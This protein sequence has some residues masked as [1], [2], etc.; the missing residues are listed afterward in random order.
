MAAWRR[1]ALESF[2]QFRRELN[3][4]GFSIYML[5]FELVPLV[6]QAH[7]DADER[8]LHEIYGFANWCFE[9]HNGELRNATGV[10]YYEHLFDD[11]SLRHDVAKWIT[12]E[13]ERSCWCL[14]ELRLESEKLLALRG[15]FTERDRIRARKRPQ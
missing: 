8:T 15:V 4:P 2:P 11:W 14:W 7:K 12:P 13:I 6:R 5:Y 3:D 1:K 9:Q 10:A